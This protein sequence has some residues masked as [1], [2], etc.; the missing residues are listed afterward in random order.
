MVATGQR[1][2]A[3][4]SVET[5]PLDPAALRGPI[6]LR[7][8]HLALGYGRR[9]IVRNLSLDIRAGDRLGIV[10][11]N[12]CGK[13]TLLRVLLGLMKPLAGR[14]VRDPKLVSSYVPQRDRLDTLL[15]LTAFEVVVMGC[16]ARCMPLRRMEPAERQRA[17]Q[18]MTTM[19]VAALGPQLFRNLSRGQQQ[20]VL[21]ARALAADPA[22]LIL[23]EPTAG[24]DIASESAML[25]LLRELSRT[26]GITILFVTHVLSLVL[27]FATT[28]LL[29]NAD[30]T[31]YG[32]I[33]DVLRADRLSALYG[34]P[35]HIGR[36]ANQ[37]MIA[38]GGQEG[39]DV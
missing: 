3:A 22:I 15:P 6:A 39:R 10:G 30:E 17:H 28:V 25:T 38:V 24:M 8:E 5:V 19:D 35:V 12:G 1:A 11:P 37:R 13:T 7:A 32:R 33:D 9:V 20:R 36:V 29:M 14:V 18:A 23:D 26:R 21:I 27:N 4:I 2:S 31:R 34:V 16:A